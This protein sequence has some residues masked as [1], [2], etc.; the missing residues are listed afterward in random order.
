[1]RIGIIAALPGELKPLVRG[2]EQ[3]PSGVKGLNIWKT[4]RGDHEL[5]AVNGGM[6]SHAAARSVTAAEFL[7]ALDALI[8]V[9]W[10]G[11]LE[12]RM[13]IG[14]CY[15][16]SL[17]IDVQTGE[18]FSTTDKSTELRLAT[19]PG[20]VDAAEKQRLQQSYGTSL[21]DMEAATVARLATMRGI[22]FY[23]FK[24]VS[25]GRDAQLPDFNLFVNEQGQMKMPAFLAHVV[26][27]PQFWGSLVELGKNSSH[28]AK[29]I[30]DQVNDFLNET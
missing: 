5:I 26:V 21:V 9:G 6:G 13:E 20:V 25:D 19:T 7:G 18:R 16:P 8:S 28:A 3:Q 10:A 14:R 2:W 30:A 12:D 29:A 4:I 1:M 27:R 22:P 24:A 17:V 23:C 11:A 15:R